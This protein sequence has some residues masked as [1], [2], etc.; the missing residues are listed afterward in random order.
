MKPYTSSENVVRMLLMSILAFSLSVVWIQT[1]LCDGLQPTNLEKEP[2]PSST[3]VAE[4][5][6]DK[7]AGLPDGSAAQIIYIDPKTGRFG[8]PPAG[9]RP[10]LSAA[11]SAAMS[12]S[13]EGL[14]ETP[15]PTPGGGI[16]VDL[17]GR[18][19]SP[20]TATLDSEGNLTIHHMPDLPAAEEKK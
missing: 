2:A 11:E 18:F 3:T 19:Q 7:A 16:M 5:R 13:H 8:P 14:V 1:A 17:K 15:S 10:A 6:G 12:T 4:V 20:V 9:A